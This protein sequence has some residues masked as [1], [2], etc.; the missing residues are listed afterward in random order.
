MNNSFKTALTVALLQRY[1]LDSRS[2]SLQLLKQALNVEL[3]CGI[4]DL[5]LPNPAQTLRIMSIIV[6]LMRIIVKK[7]QNMSPGCHSTCL[8]ADMEAGMF[9]SVAMPSQTALHRARIGVRRPCKTGLRHSKIIKII[10]RV[11]NNSCKN[12]SV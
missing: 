4:H 10:Y 11:W 7:R 1:K 2:L 5:Y 6:K 8:P 3:Q 12:N 9:F